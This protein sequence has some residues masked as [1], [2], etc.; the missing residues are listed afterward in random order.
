ME[1]R[2]IIGCD[3]AGRGPLAG[4]VYAAAVVLPEKFNLDFLNDSK[5]MTPSQRDISRQYIIKNALFYSIQSI[6][7]Q[8]IDRINILNAS[9]KAMKN[10]ALEVISSIPN[11]QSDNILILV[12]GNRIFSTEYSCSSVIKGDSSVPE[13]MAA[14]IL[15]KTERDA[16]MTH[17]DKDYPQYGF[18]K[19]KGYGTKEHYDAL[20]KYGACPLH[21]KSF[22]LRQEN[23]IQPTLFYNG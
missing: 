6:S 14:S 8:E 11:I 21:R 16:Y 17:A 15:A 4:P 7:A 2:I 20:K 1:K 23:D 19:H 10:A 18:A 12:D 3:E 13:I 22:R 5:K 9:L